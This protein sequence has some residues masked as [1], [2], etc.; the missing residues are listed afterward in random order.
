MSRPWYAGTMALAPWVSL[1]I[2]KH[3]ELLTKCWH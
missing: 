2:P 1:M 3:L